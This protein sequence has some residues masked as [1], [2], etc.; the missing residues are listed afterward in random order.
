ML[1]KE[2]PGLE[3]EWNHFVLG[4]EPLLEFMELLDQVEFRKNGLPRAGT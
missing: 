2:A 1:S 4:Q 3:T